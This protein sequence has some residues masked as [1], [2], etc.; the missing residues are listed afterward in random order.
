VVTNGLVTSTIGGHRIRFDATNLNE[1][2]GVPSDGFDVYVCEDKNVLGDERLLEM[3]R[4][5][6]QNLQLTMSRSIH[7]GEMITLHCLL[8]WFIIKNVIP[9]G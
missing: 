1:M 2:L 6:A 4:N 8:F 9:W 7:K 3:T 5:L